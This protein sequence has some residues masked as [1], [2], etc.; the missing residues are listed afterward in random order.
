MEEEREER[1]RNTE[2]ISDKVCL[3]YMTNKHE[4]TT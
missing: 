2:W 3:K 1:I 4:A